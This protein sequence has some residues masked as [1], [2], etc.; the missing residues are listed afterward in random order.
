MASKTTL[1]IAR[2]RALG[3]RIGTLPGHWPT[4]PKGANWQYVITLPKGIEAPVGAKHGSLKGVA[5]AHVVR[6]GRILVQAFRGGD[7][8]VRITKAEREAIEADVAGL[9]SQLADIL[10]GR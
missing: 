6:D 2:L 4:A 8:A 5:S 9:L 10:N 3:C 7:T 1:P